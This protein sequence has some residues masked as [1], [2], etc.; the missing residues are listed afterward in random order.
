MQP[1]PVSASRALPARWAE[2]QRPGAGAAAD[3]DRASFASDIRRLLAALDQRDRDVL[4]LIYV[5][6]LTQAQAAQVLGLT[7]AVVGSRVVRALRD[8]AV[9]VA[10]G[11]SSPMSSGPRS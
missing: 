6:G 7:G 3:P 8:L 4:G 9:L 2:R 1:N 11:T 10:P 5:A